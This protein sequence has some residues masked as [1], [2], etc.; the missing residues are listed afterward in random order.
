MNRKIFFSVFVVLIL[1][2]LGVWF[3]RSRGAAYEKPALQDPI[4][5]SS[6]VDVSNGEVTKTNTVS[7]NN[8]L[9]EFLER[10]PTN[11]KSEVLLVNGLPVMQVMGI[12]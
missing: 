8:L 6:K 10:L 1:V 9:D 3:F 11:Q 5:E 4:S 2:S 7:D 12:T